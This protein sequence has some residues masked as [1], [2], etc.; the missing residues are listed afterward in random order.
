VNIMFKCEIC[1]LEFKSIIGISNHIA[2]THKL[3]IE[4]YY[5]K[6]INPEKGTCKT[7]GKNTRFCNLRLGYNKFCS[8]KCSG[9]HPETIQ[10]SM[11]TCMKNF[12][13]EH[14][15]QSPEVREKSMNTCLKNFD[16]KNPMQN[17][18]VKKRH[19]DTCMKNWNVENPSQNLE[20]KNKKKETSIKNWNVEN[21]NQNIIIKEK[22]KKT[23]L[24]NCGFEY[25]FQ[26]PINKE[27]S[28]ETYMKKT[29]YE[30]PSQNP[31]VKEKSINTCMKN[32]NVRYPGQNHEVIK[33]IK[34]ST[35]KNNNGVH[36]NKLTYKKCLEK[37]PDVV[38]IEGLIEGP[39]GEIW[40]HC[41]NANC[42]NSKENGGYFELTS[43]QI[44][45]RNRGINGN[46]TDNFYCCEECKH[47]C[48]LFNRTATEL[49]NLINENKEIP[50]TQPELSTWREE[51][52]LRQRIEYDIDYNFCEHCQ[53]KEK[54][55]AH[56]I[57][58]IKLYP[59]YALDPDNGI[60]FCEDCHYE[61][62]HETGTECST[63]N[64]ASKI[65]K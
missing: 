18:E 60:I 53:S 14:S 54:L 36:P 58:P 55:H 56:H 51:V 50:Y 17:L 2:R 10:K 26:N 49:H 1:G 9:M 46:D 29:G 15:M 33:K 21:P 34:E 35:L 16:V 39:N 28:K 11:N 6:H 30:N 47:S 57:Q 5:L 63:G 40:G 25:S 4:D 3:K 43:G 64:L 24:K 61:I 37:Y 41:K 22:I 31:I 48:P 32:L 13:V 8:K 19:K 42:K 20:V 12:G 7:C 59:G 45:M 44:G 65:C 38:K 23:N 27:K 52:F 62:G